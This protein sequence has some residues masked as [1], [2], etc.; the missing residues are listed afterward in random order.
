M[1]LHIM[2][3]DGE[4]PE[5]FAERMKQTALRLRAVLDEALADL[6]LVD[7]KVIDHLL[8]FDA[9][10]DAPSYDMKLSVMQTAFNSLFSVIVELR[11]DGMLDVYR[12][13]VARCKAA[14]AKLN[15]ELAREQ[16][17]DAAVH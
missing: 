6:E 17:G 5:A 4:T 2:R 11:P 14:G 9:A 15:V 13:H 1:M 7:R 16:K 10:L 3:L 8:T 12:E